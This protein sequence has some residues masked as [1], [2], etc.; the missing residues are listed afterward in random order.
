MDASEY[1]HDYLLLLSIE[2]PEKKIVILLDSLDQL[3]TSDYNIEWL[4]TD[5]PENIKMIYSTLPNHGGILSKLESKIETN[6]SN[7]MEVESLTKAIVITILEDWLS[8]SKRSVSEEQWQILQN[9][10]DSA[11]L[12]PLYV[13]LIYDII[14]KWTSFHV[15]SS[16]FQQCTD[17]DGCI[18]YLFQLL[19]INHGKTLFS[20][21]LFYL[22]TFKNGISE[23]ELEDILSIDDDVLYEI[24]EYHIPPVNFFKNNFKVL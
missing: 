17:I 19:E 18:R 7:F 4:F 9:I 22:S 2:Y 3:A 8:K 14:H 16:A 12:Y 24:F 6:E 13:K 1:L 15:P 5:L 23:S 21:A 10:F 20:R 11:K